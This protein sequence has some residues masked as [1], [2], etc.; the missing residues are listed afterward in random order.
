MGC[1]NNNVSEEDK[2]FSFKRKL[3]SQTESN[4]TKLNILNQKLTKI[5]MEIRQLESDIRLNNT[6]MNEIELKNKAKKIA[7]LKKDEIRQQKEVKNLTIL[8]DTMKNNLQMMESKIEEYRNAKSIEE[9]NSILKDIYKMDFHKTYSKN[10]DI[11]MK[12]KQ[13]NDDNMRVLEAGNNLYLSDN[14]NMVESPDDILNNLLRQG[15]A[16]V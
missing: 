8:N 11:L 14:G 5:Q 7:E 12:N 4:K 13:Q 6:G 1:S 9:A 16:P 10:V 2:L 3:I 15:P